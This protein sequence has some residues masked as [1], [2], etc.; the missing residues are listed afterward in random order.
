MK[1][2][3]IKVSLGLHI[4]HQHLQ[5]FHVSLL[6]PQK[7]LKWLNMVISRKLSFSLNCSEIHFEQMFW[8][9]K[10]DLQADRQNGLQASLSAVP[11]K[12]YVH[13]YEGPRVILW[14]TT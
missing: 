5:V 3:N 13:R 14:Q 7:Q 9:K 1:Y 10:K 12:F 4:L 11:V 6:Q 8:P 2:H